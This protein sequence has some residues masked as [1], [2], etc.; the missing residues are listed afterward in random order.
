LES[1][2]KYNQVLQQ[3]FRQ[4]DIW[5]ILSEENRRRVDTNPLRILD[6]KDFS[7]HEAA[8]RVPSI[9]NYLSKES[10]NDF[11]GIQEALTSLGIEYTV[12]P[13]MVR[14]LDYYNDLCFEIKTKARTASLYQS[15]PKFKAADITGWR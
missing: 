7:S 6:S 2:N 1:R 12:D 11:G 3:Y 9:L 4:N 14:G 5:S 10:S 15:A 13:M 8:D